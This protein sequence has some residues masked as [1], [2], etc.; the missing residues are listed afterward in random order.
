M[1][2]KYIITSLFFSISFSQESSNI[3]NDETLSS[4]IDIMESTPTKLDFKKK[5]EILENI[6]KLNNKEKKKKILKELTKEKDE[7]T[8]QKAVIELSKTRDSDVLDELI[9]NIESS[10]VALA[11]AS[12]EG[13]RNYQKNKKA[14]VAVIKALKNKEKNI[15]WQAVVVCGEMKIDGCVNGIGGI[16]KDKDEDIYVIRSAIDS[17]YKIR[18]QKA[19]NLL[20]SFATSDLRQEIKTMC[21][22]V[23]SL[24][25]K[26]RKK[27]KN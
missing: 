17:L 4:Y 18:T 20:N 1:M 19:I 12:L 14:E 25:N 8:K 6:N 13:L 21:K 26:E 3:V 24:I 7:V 16:I 15:R 5:R 2:L 9:K 11:V 10:D 22:N 23:I 27:K